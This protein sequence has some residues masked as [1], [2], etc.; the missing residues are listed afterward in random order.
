MK[1][2]ISNHE[3]QIRANVRNAYFAESSAVIKQEL[4]RRQARNDLLVVKF[5]RELL[6]ENKQDESNKTN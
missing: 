2:Q 1:T 5:L 3:R 6:D 4:D